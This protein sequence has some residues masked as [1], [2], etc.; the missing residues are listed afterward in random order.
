MYLI[1]NKAADL[2]LTGFPNP[3]SCIK[4]EPAIFKPSI[5]LPTDKPRLLSREVVE[6]LQMSVCLTQ[7]TCVGHRMLISSHCYSVV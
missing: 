6:Y 5:R 2:G 7:G 3:R 4:T 1:S